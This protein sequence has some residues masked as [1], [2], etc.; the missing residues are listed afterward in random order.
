MKR[1]KERPTSAIANLTKPLFFFWGGSPFC[2]I[3]I[4][5]NISASIEQRKFEE[6]IM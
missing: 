5:R 3:Q 6:K 2:N 1:S 4:S